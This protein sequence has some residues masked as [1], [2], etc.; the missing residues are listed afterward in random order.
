[1]DKVINCLFAAIT[2][3]LSVR[4]EV[5]KGKKD[6][7]EMF[8]RAEQS[9]FDA[10]RRSGG[11]RHLNSVCSLFIFPLV[12]YEALPNVC[13]VNSSTNSNVKV[14][15]LSLYEGGSLLKK[16]KNVAHI[17]FV[18]Q[19]AATA[20]AVIHQQFVLIFR[21][22]VRNEQVRRRHRSD[23]V[24]FGGAIYATPSLKPVRCL[25]LTSSC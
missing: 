21:A 20:L 3:L 16:K 13:G 19:F 15:W 9:L 1:M 2:L 22:A 23:R 14:M 18:P 11:E 12:L 6:L 24:A 4:G 5:F 17:W 10:E 8:K 7:L 25:C